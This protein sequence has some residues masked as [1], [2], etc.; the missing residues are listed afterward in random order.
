MKRIMKNVFG[1]VLILVFTAG[2]TQAQEKKEQQQI[3]IIITEKDGKKVVI[4][5]TFSSV[6]T[7]DSIR[8]KDGQMV[9]IGKN[10]GLTSAH[11]STGARGKVVIVEGMPLHSTGEHGNVMTWVSSEDGSEGKSIVYVHKTEP[12]VKDGEVRYNVEVKTDG[13]GK[14][15]EKT[16]Y[17]VAKDGMVVT[18]EGADEAKVKELATVVESKLGVA[19]DGKNGSQEV[20]EETKKTVKK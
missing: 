14:T 3:K 2:F 15:T 8:L 5:T 13:S 16:S 19:K 12:G 11:V 18:I 7:I 6:A 9:Y 17:V 4:D 10:D 1:L 20:K